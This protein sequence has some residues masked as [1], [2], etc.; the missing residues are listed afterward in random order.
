MS[1]SIWLSLA[2][3]CLLGAM[4]PGPSL[5]VVLGT[6]WQGGRAAG[7]AVALSHGAAVGLYALLTVA[8]L[9]ALLVA[10]PGL[11]TGLQL[12]SA[13]YLLYLA[14]TALRQG[15]GLPV[16]E[17]GS[18][19]LKSTA[20]AARDGFLIAFLNPKL[21]IF[22]LALFAPFVSAD[23]SLAAKA[24][25][26]LTIGGIDAL[27]Y[28]LVVLVVVR[29]GLLPLLARNAAR[30]ARFYALLLVAFAVLIVSRALG[31]LI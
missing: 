21:A 15:T 19:E 5:A 1:L 17:A 25:L 8:G 13:G 11:F 29:G 6:T 23:Q 30:V 22:M 14:Y 9:A 28:S 31:A 12:A 2:L 7:L 10:A 20:T 24:V 26:V 18:R 16:A 27:W 3:L 4:T